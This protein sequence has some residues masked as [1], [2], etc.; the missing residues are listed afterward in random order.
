MSETSFPLNDLLRRKLQTSLTLISLIICVASTLFLLL[1]SNKIGLGI[2][3][4]VEGKLTIGF[5]MIFSPF[6][7]FVEI[8]A[9]I[10]GAVIISFMIFVMMSQRVKDIGLMKASGCPNGLIF[11]YFMTELVII[12]F[13][14]CFLGAIF[15]IMAD[16]ASTNFFSNF[17]LEISQKPID[18][19]LVLLMTALFFAI[20]LI[21]GAKPILDTAKIAPAKAASPTYYIGLTKERGFSVTSKFGFT[22]KIAFRSLFRRKSATIRIIACLSIVYI[23]ITVAV[24]GGIIADKTTKNWVEK[25]IGK[26]ILVIGHQEMCNQY[27]LLLS[28]FME[29]KI[30]SPFNYSDE[31]YL[32][33]EQFQAQLFSTEKN[34]SFETRLLLKAQV[35]EIQGILYGRTTEDMIIVGDD[36]KGESLIVGVEPGN[37]LSDWFLNGRFISEDQGI[38]A[39]LGDTLSQKMFSVPLVQEI[40]LFNTDF[41]IVGVCLDPVNNGNVTYVPLKTLQ[42]ITGISKPN[43]IMAKINSLINRTNILAQI[44]EKVAN[45]NSEFT[46]FELNE[47]LNQ[48]QNYLGLIWSTMMFLPLSC[49]VA[50]SLCLIAYIILSLNEQ[51]QEFGVLRALGAKPKTIL[52]IVSAQSLVVLLSSFSVGISFGIIITLLILIP[53]PFITVYTIIEIAS[54]LIIALTSTFALSLLPTIKIVKKPLPE[55]MAQS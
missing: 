9:F 29:T 16:F 6:I 10:V 4:A 41:K 51:C 54:W 38:E 2:S 28:K 30:D 44:R 47:I 37:V 39:V 12:T 50:S 43:I 45:I 13:L 11:G 25:A 19:R 7:I 33:S 27:K 23:V 42:N 18:F 3:A 21:F 17:N 52:K 40:K 34:V 5:S 55:L 20:A 26:D 53:E 31:K 32:I 24:A 36:R 1:F 14:G 22:L 15:G 48:T 49:L 46:V 8:L 35:K